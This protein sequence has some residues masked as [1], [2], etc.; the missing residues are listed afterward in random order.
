MH[1]ED[2]LINNDK[3]L[4][5]EF[6]ALLDK[7]TELQEGNEEE[8]NFRI[9]LMNKLLSRVKAAPFNYK[10]RREKANYGDNISS[11]T[12]HLYSMLI[13]VFQLHPCYMYNFLQKRGLEWEKKIS[14]I[15]LVYGNM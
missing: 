7:F 11:D 12:I 10:D 14:A 1:L 8:E 9:G 2:Q 3:Q 5:L 15:E 4:K 13:T 6:R